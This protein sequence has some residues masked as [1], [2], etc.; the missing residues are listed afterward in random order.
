MFAARIRHPLR[1]E[2]LANE[3]RAQFDADLMRWSDFLARQPGL[4][5][6]TVLL[7][8]DSL[9]ALS[10][11]ADEAAFQGTFAHSDCPAA[12]APLTAL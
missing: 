7:E 10:L 1:P 2:A 5:S 6:F 9:F 12:G 11:W 3:N 4:D 8:A